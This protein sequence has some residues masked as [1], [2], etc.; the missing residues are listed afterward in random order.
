MIT[1]I[2]KIDGVDFKTAARHLG[3]D[4]YRPSPEQQ[5]IKKQAERIAWWARNTS[6][7]LCDSLRAIGDK[8]QTCSI[9]RKQPA[10]DRALQEAL[11]RQWEI[12]CDLDDDPSNPKLVLDLWGQR[13]E[14]DRFVESLA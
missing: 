14:I 6:N 8:I 11:I 9:A 10:A 4:I 1:F 5:Q 13:E 3:R 7:R 2:E 12:L